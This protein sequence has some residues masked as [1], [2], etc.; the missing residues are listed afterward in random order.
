MQALTGENGPELVQTDGG[1]YIVGQNGPEMANIKK[2]DTVYTADETKKILK[3]SKHKIAPRFATGYGDATGGSGGR[4]TSD[5]E[6]YKTSIDKLY[7]LLRDIDEEMRIREQLERRYI[8]ALEGLNTTA[9]Q[10]IDNSFAELEQLEVQRELNEERIAGRQTQIKQYEEENSQYNKY[11][12]SE[13]DEHGNMVLRID[14]EAI[15]A[16]TDEEEGKA[17]ETYLNQLEEWHGDIQEAE[18]NLEDIED[19]TK[20]INQRGKDEY[21]NLEQQVKDALVNERQKEIDELSKINESINDTNSRLIEAMQESIEQ[22]RQ[23]RENQRTEEDLSDKQRRLAYLQQDTSGANALEIL[24]LQKELDQGI[25]DY[26]DTLIDQKISELQKQNDEAAEQRERQI[27]LA[28]AQLEYDVANGILWDQV[29]ALMHEGID[30]NGVIID[31]SALMEKLKTDQ[32]YASKSNLEKLEWAESLND[33][34]AQALQWLQVGRQVENLDME[35]QTIEFTTKDGKTVK[36]KIDKEGNVTT[37][38][39]MVYEGVYQNYDGTFKTEE[40]WKDPSKEKEEEK[41]EEQV[42][43]PEPT[44]PEITVGSKIDAKGAK[45]YGW[46]GGKGQKQYFDREPVFS[47]FYKVVKDD[48]DWIQ[49]AWYKNPDDPT[50]WFKKKDVKLAAYEHGGMA[51]FTGPAWLDGTKSKPEYVLNA[52]QTRAFF[53]LVDV[54]QSL[55]SGTSKPSENSG[56]S[57]FDI[58]INVESI[59]SDYDVDQLAERVKNLINDTARYRNNNTTSSTR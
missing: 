20:E 6:G 46:K 48:G 32:D 22:Q 8:K 38:D 50:G 56:D 55:Q 45:I 25:E 42:Q 59:G 43:E 21:F 14:W 5:E 37:K 47:P 29:Y 53:T 17:V 49:A 27:E 3:G 44:T 35:G 1:Y 7:N 52:D 2:G 51:D 18:K 11:A 58:D 13:I 16:I 9:K 15:N 40:N 34:A 26:T 24:T 54:L 33:T 41:E 36:G 39:G 23:E 28:E 4:S 10:L 57:S 31:G 30:E 19:E 12:K